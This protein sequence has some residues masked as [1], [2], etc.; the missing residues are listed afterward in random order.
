M[1]I[2]Q[3]NDDLGIDA[4]RFFRLE[5]IIS[6]YRTDSAPRRLISAHLKAVGSILNK[7]IIYLLAGE[8]FI[9]ELNYL[10]EEDATKM[11]K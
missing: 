1:K 4:A 3:E 7:E 5:E 9:K 6:N 8:I 10:L 2:F 11:T